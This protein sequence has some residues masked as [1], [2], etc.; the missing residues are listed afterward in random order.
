MKNLLILILFFCLAARA[1][2]KPNEPQTYEC[3]Y[4]T[5]MNQFIDNGQK[6][7]Q[8]ESKLIITE[9]RSLFFTIPNAETYKDVGDDLNITEEEDTLFKIT[10]LNESNILLFKDNYFLKKGKIYSDTLFPM[11][12]DLK[13]EKKMIDSLG[14]YKA[15]AFY[16]GRNYV[17]WY[18]PQILIPDGPWKLGGLPGLIIEAYDE[19]KQ[20]QFILKAFKVLNKTDNINKYQIY[21]DSK[22]ASSFSDYVNTGNLFIKKVKEQML[23]QQSGSC[24]TCQTEPKIEFHFLEKVFN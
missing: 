10:K 14:C 16:K 18:C 17:A 3:E 23:A 8:F 1:Q 4:A 15:T 19:T 13:N 2:N 22:T 20:I 21:F 11:K 7:M 12:W 6:L 9:S 5:L 24:L